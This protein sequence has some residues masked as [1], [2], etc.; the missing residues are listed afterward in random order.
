M[1]K[2]EDWCDDYNESSGEADEN[3]IDEY[4]ITSTPN[5]FNVL[6]LNSFVEAGAVRIPGF[7]RNFVWDHPRAS[8]LIESLILGLPVPQIFLYEQ[9]R[10]KFLVID[11]QQRLMTI[12]YFMKM[13]FPR[14]DKRVEIREIFDKNGK[15]TDE[16]L[17]DSNYFDEFKLRLPSS[18]PE[19]T[20]KFHGLNYARLGEY[21]TQ[22]E[23]RPIRN[24]VVK[25]NAPS[26]DD[27]SMYEIFN[28][29]NTGGVNLRAQEIRTSMYHSR[30]YEMLYRVNRNS[31]WR[32]IIT[33]SDPDIH[34]KDIEI[35]LRGYALLIDGHNYAPSMLRFLNKFSRQC[36]GHTEQ[37]NEYLENLFKS[38][39]TSCQEFPE[40]AFLNNKNKRFNIALYEAVFTAACRDALKENRILN[41]LID[42]KSVDALK[43]DQAFNNA[44]QEGTTGTSNVK[45][46]LSRAADIIKFI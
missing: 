46:R 31:E 39:L 3:Q 10:N 13:R 24:I 20:N 1:V 45:T 6:T 16:I 36:R 34:M 30:F 40:G 32:S 5:D 2:E 44:A 4:D 26:D 38:F 35:I 43:N 18:I 23:L 41:S 25:Q 42:Y 21:K 37:Y 19:N 11:G 9:A 14:K 27:S 28:R 15:I 12:Y 7:Q 8:K 17:H 29:L 33:F 22:F